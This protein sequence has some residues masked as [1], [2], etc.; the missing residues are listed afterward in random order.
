MRP[1]PRTRV[2]N[3]FSGVTAP[4]PAQEAAESSDSLQCDSQRKH[5]EDDGDKRKEQN[6]S[7]KMGSINDSRI[8]EDEGP[9]PAQ[10][11]PS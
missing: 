3:H 9:D 4:W 8:H 2:S 10:P 5:P 1:A 11:V 7:Q 6:H